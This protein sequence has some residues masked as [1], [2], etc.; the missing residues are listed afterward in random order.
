MKVTTRKGKA[1]IKPEGELTIMKAADFKDALVKS[2]DKADEVEINLEEVTSIDVSCLQLMCSAHR[3][4]SKQKKTLG[5]KDPTL[6]VF[7]KVRKDAGF[8]FAKSCRFVSTDDCL[9]VGEGE[10]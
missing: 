4:A 6:P 7:R 10:K 9:W 1:Y 8:I 3:T 5:V 2:L